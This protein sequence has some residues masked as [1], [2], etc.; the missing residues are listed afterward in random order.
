MHGRG[1]FRGRQHSGLTSTLSVACITRHIVDDLRAGAR[2]A[3]VTP[4][5]AQAGARHVS[6]QGDRRCGRLPVARRAAAETPFDIVL[7]ARRA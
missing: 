3:G 2:A 4:G 1:A 6:A 5:L 7:E